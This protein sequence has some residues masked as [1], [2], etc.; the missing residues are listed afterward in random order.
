MNMNMNMNMKCDNLILLFSE[1]I[2]FQSRVLTGTHAIMLCLLH[3][4]FDKYILNELLGHGITLC[5][6]DVILNCTIMYLLP[7][8]MEN[9]VVSF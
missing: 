4:F 1:Y 9:Y 6:Q 8:S 7:A 3:Y 5:C 2:S